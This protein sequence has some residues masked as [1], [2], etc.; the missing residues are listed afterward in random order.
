[1]AKQLAGIFVLFLSLLSTSGYCAG[2]M[3]PEEIRKIESEVLAAFGSLVDASKALDSARYFEHFDKEKFTGLNADGKVWHSI[4]ELE[5]LVVPGFFDGGQKHCA[6]IH[7]C[8]SDRHR[9]GDSDTG[10]RIQAEYSAKEWQYSQQSR[11][12]RTS[13]A[14]IRR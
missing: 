9:W 2:K 3:K 12:W 7:E 5:S 10:Q 6:R 1:M 4:K 11:W 8:E 13:L 14:S